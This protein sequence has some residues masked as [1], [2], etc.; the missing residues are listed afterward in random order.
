M[1]HLRGV[2]V[3][4][5]DSYGDNLQ[6]W[7]TRYLR[8]GT[9]GK[10]VSAYVQSTTNA[11]FHVTLQPNIPF[12][13]T[14]PPP[15]SIAGKAY[16]TE[17]KTRHSTASSED[18]STRQNHEKKDNDA[19]SS[20]I[21]SSTTSQYHPTPDFAF[22]AVLYLDGRKLPERKISKALPKYFPVF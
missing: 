2:T 18:L 3:H 16:V 8:H 10:K 11:A 15:D 5:T 21:R 4:I 7:G 1:P 17:K 12:I 13:E 9:G 20:P 14:F 19:L 6:E 22:L